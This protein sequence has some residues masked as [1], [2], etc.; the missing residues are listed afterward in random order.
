MTA[1][2]L[3]RFLNFCS[4]LT[5][6]CNRKVGIIENG[7]WAPMAGKKIKEFLTGMKNIEI[8]EP[9]VTVK[10]AMKQ[11]TIKELESLADSLL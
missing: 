3:L 8:V 4:T 1:E 6:K 7:S 5:Q 11:N 9:T 10:S 2:Y